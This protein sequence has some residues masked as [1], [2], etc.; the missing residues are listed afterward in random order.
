[1]RE[2]FS[3]FP[4]LR[5][6]QITR[7]TLSNPHT[8]FCQ[9]C[10]SLIYLPEPDQTISKLATWENV[11]HFFPNLRVRKITRTTDNSSIIYQYHT[12]QHDNQ[13]SGL[14]HNCSNTP[15]PQPTRRRPNI[16]ATPSDNLL[17]LN[18]I[19]PF[20]EP[21][22]GQLQQNCSNTDLKLF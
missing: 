7:T 19:I 9:N 14:F 21:L 8:G 10:I 1:M 4:N 22:P 18:S 16:L 20:T 5:V 2:C 11:F 13:K 15:P 12:C 3:F 17:I 6:R